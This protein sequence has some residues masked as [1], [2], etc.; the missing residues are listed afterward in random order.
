MM[1]ATQPCAEEDWREHAFDLARGIAVFTGCPLVKGVAKVIAKHPEAD[2]GNAF[3]HKQVACKMWARDRLYESVGG[4]F[5]EIWIVGGWYGVL[6]GMLLE[7]ER[8]KIG[9]IENSDIDPMAGQIAE[10]LN[11]AHQ[12]RFEA[13]TADMYALDYAGRAPDLVVNT[14]CEHI[15]DLRAWLS[16]MAKGQRVLLQSNDYFSEPTHIACVP[17]LKAF[18]ELAGLSNVDFAGELPMKKYTRFMLI[19]RV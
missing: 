18:E 19:G 7:D 11:H 8:F 12:T 9:R 4:V 2:I 14:S 5:G 1:D 16:R 17:S 15:P 10:T 3:N 13:I 6:A